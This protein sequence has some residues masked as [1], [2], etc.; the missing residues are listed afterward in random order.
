MIPEGAK[1]DTE[2]HCFLGHSSFIPK[3]HRKSSKTV[4][5]R[6]KQGTTY[7]F[8]IFSLKMVVLAI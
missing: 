3:E 4:S 2:G 5:E 1:P 7:N 8:N 6:S